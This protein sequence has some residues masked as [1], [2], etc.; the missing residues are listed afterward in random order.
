MKQTLDR[1][2]RSLI[3]LVDA[4][5]PWALKQGL[6]EL[7]L[8]HLFAEALAEGDFGELEGRVLRLELEDATTGVTLG[9]WGGRL[10]MAYAEPEATIRGTTEAFRRLAERRE[11]PDRLFFQ[12]QLVIEGD[13]EL[14]LAVK[15]LLDALEWRIPLLGAPSGVSAPPDAAG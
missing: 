10:R 4:R 8:N 9:F 3:P 5:L 11:D 6:V 2:A 13:T 14:G 7:P 12:R 1:M 15:N